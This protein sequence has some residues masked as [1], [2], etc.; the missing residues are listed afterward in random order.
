MGIS[1]RIREPFSGLSHLLG[2]LMSLILLAA[3]L[4][5]AQGRTWETIAY[6]AYGGSLVALYT[7]SAVYHSLRVSDRARAWLQRCDHAAI[8][9]L[10]AGTYTPVCVL[11]LRGRGGFVV[12]ALEWAL[13]ATG[14][15][16]L[17]L[18]RNAPHAVRVALYIAMGW[19]AVA[20]WPQLRAAMSSQALWWILAG[21]LVYTGG[22]VFYALD[23][24]RIGRTPL[25]AHD[26][27]HLFVMGGSACHAVAILHIALAL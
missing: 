8:F 25:T 13:A 23:Q 4:V 22:V 16:G 5:L 20:V 11:A 6:L 7:A 27:W 14:I 9:L 1:G 19:L 3:L 10:I 18:W 26:V 2:A 21:G 15:L 17:F 12:L 24:R